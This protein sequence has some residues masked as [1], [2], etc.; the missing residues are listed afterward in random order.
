MFE[1]GE[2]SEAL[3]REVGEHLANRLKAR[4]TPFVVLAVGKGA[5]PL[6]DAVRTVHPTAILEI[7]PSH[8][9]ALTWVQSYMQAED[10]LFVKGS[11]G[12]QLDKLVAQLE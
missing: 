1:L 4:P 11:R 7:F 8:A 5:R 9:E 10:V 6:L 3:H 12:V 2:F